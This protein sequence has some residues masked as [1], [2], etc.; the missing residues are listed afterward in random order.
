[1]RECNQQNKTVKE[2]NRFHHLPMAGGWE[3]VVYFGTWGW[4]GRIGILGPGGPPG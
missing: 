3:G 4:G 2:T 1:M